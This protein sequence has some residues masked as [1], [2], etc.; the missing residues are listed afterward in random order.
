MLDGV[1]LLWYLLTAGSYGA[2]VLA[3][4]LANHGVRTLSALLNLRARAMGQVYSIWVAA[5]TLTD[6][7]RAIPPVKTSTT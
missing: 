2:V 7:S 4:L 1:L 5:V 3:A 6:G